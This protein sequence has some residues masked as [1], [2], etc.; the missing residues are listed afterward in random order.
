MKLFCCLLQVFLLF[1]VQILTIG[2]NDFIQHLRISTLPLYL[3]SSFFN[4]VRHIWSNISRPSSKRFSP[5]IRCF[6]W[7]L[8]GPNWDVSSSNVMWLG[9]WKL[10]RHGKLHSLFRF[11]WLLSSLKDLIQR[12]LTKILNSFVLRGIINWGFMIIPIEVCFYNWIK[13]E[14]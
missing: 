13:V 6:K 5:K 2:H 10:T 1:N 11:C 4:S 12:G 3:T 9:T 14:C 8:W 7:N